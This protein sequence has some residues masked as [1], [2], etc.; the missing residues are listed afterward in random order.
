MLAAGNIAAAGVRSI[1]HRSRQALG[2]RDGVDIRC[3]LID[4]Q[5]LTI[6]NTIDHRRYLGNIHG[7]AGLLVHLI[8]LV[9]VRK[10][11]SIVQYLTVLHTYSNR[12]SIGLPFT[13]VHLIRDLLTALTGNGNG[14]ILID[15]NTGCN[16][17]SIRSLRGHG[18][19]IAYLFKG[20]GFGR[21]KAGRLA[22]VEQSCG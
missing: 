11:V 22:V 19:R 20:D 21:R 12:S 15:L 18:Q 5:F 9:G 14:D 3:V 6:R 4:R 10:G 7:K 17:L 2:Q 16:G 13:A 8:L 1:V